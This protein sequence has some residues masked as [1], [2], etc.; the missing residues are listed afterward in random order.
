MLVEPNR[1]TLLERHVAISR[2]LVDLRSRRAVILARNLAP[3]T[4]SLPC[5]ISLA[6]IDAASFSDDQGRTSSTES[7][8]G[9]ALADQDTVSVNVRAMIDVSLKESEQEML[10]S[11]LRKHAAPF[12]LESLILGRATEVRIPLTPEI[13]LL[14][15]RSG[16]VFRRQGSRP[17]IKRW[18]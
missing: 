18:Q 9:A 3:S 2:S 7:Q 17:F 16:I 12:H 1:A 8:F 10:V 13:P 14:C 15:L 11:I 4:E 5:G 6:T